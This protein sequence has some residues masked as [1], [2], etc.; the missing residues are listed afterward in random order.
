MSQT[1]GLGYRMWSL[2]VLLA[3][4][5]SYIAIERSPQHSATADSVLGSWAPVLYKSAQTKMSDVRRSDRPKW[6]G[7]FVLSYI[8]KMRSYCDE[9]ITTDIV[10]TK[11][12][13]NRNVEEYK[14]S[15]SIVFDYKMNQQQAVSNQEYKT[16]SNKVYNRLNFSCEDDVNILAS[17][18]E[19]DGRAAIEKMMG[20]LGTEQHQISALTKELSEVK[21]KLSSMASFADFENQLGRIIKEWRLITSKTTV[22]SIKEQSLKSGFLRTFVM[23]A[24]KDVFQDVWRDAM[25]ITNDES[26]ATIMKNCKNIS[27]ALG[28]SV[29]PT[30]HANSYADSLSRRSNYNGFGGKG[31]GKGNGY[32]GSG[33]KGK[34]KGG[35]FNNSERGERG[36][37]PWNERKNDYFRCSGCNSDGHFFKF[38]AQPGGPY[39][40]RLEEAIRDKKLFLAQR[41]AQRKGK[42]KGY[43][44]Y[45]KGQWS[46]MNHR[47][48]QY[49]ADSRFS[50]Y[51]GP[52]RISSQAMEAQS[53]LNSY[54][55]YNP[56]PRV[57]QENPDPRFAPEHMSGMNRN[58][59]PPVNQQNQLGV[60]NTN[61]ANVNAVDSR[62]LANSVW[63]QRAMSGVYGNGNGVHRSFPS[64][65]LSAR[66][67]LN[68]SLLAGVTADRTH[69]F[70]CLDSGCN[71][72][73]VF[74]NMAY[75]PFEVTSDH[76]VEMWVADTHKLK[77][78]A[79]GTAYYV[80]FDEISHSEFICSME[81]A[82]YDSRYQMILIPEGHFHFRPDGVTERPNFINFKKNCMIIDQNLSEEKYVELKR[83]EKL[84]CLKMRPLNQDEI[85]KI[86]FSKGMFLFRNLI[87][88]KRYVQIQTPIPIPI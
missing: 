7:K 38:C 67:D 45:G 61:H 64:V 44:S 51:H 58:N 18:N 42:G 57:Y 25:K 56:D 78:E 53:F 84:P 76:E 24:I 40:G 52:D 46:D 50:G 32:N 20:T 74:N 83:I 37:N 10:S 49:R 88:E 77:L 66:K 65:V 31:G 2:I 69:D 9:M 86:R 22:E 33:G 85:M 16:I 23:D 60:P 41:D 55:G 26:W 59:F 6:T 4:S 82:A 5:V 3:C 35:G 79:V 54:N 73:S 75:F 48:D 34:G 12:V 1:I 19:G 70:A 14:V 11:N 27:M 30:S 29:R 36:K 62:S 15:S 8:S 71:E 43:M 63:A 28:D 13:G 68:L 81:R 17:I 72:Y 87:N 80:L 47:N 39:E 21:S